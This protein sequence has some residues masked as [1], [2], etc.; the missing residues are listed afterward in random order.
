MKKS[1]LIIALLTS[2]S[3]LAADNIIKMSSLYAGG[4]LHNTSTSTGYSASGIGFQAFVGYSLDEYIKFDEKLDL[5]AEV[6]YSTVSLD[7]D[8]NLGA[9]GTRN[10]SVDISGLWTT[11]VAGYKLTDDIKALARVGFDLGDD[12]GFMFGAGAEYSIN[13]KIAVRAEYVMRSNTDALQI[14]AIYKF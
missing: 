8:I 12:D 6:G 9:F 7:Y 13:T 10:S 11:A 14:N 5:A 3:T 1:L 2:T 4:G